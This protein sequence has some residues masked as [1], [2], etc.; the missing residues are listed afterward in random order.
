MT[1]QG[2]LRFER[3]RTNR[4]R[5]CAIATAQRLTSTWSAAG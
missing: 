2:E 3:L 4:S 5:T 1:K